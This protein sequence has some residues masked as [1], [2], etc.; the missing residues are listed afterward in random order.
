MAGAVGVAAAPILIS[1]AASMTVE[2]LTPTGAT[3]GGNNIS[4][5]AT[6]SISGDVLTIVLVNTSPANAQETPTSTLSGLYFDIAGTP[7]VTPTSATASSIANAASCNPGPC[8]GV[9][10]VDGEFG[11]AEPSGGPATYGI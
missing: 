5:T 3:I 6:F 2:F 8:T 4:A 9:H 7:S 10:N 1:K 11:F